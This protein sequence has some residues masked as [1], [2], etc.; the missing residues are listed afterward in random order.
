[1]WS[2]PWCIHAEVHLPDLNQTWT[3]SFVYLS[4][5]AEVRKVQFHSLR[6]LA[7]FNHLGDW[8][9]YLTPS[10]KWGGRPITNAQLTPFSEFISSSCLPELNFPQAFVST[11]Q[12]S[13]SDHR[14]LILHT[15]SLR[16]RVQ[17]PFRFVA[18]WTL[19][20]S[21]QDTI[22]SSWNSTQARGSAPFKLHL[23]MKALKLS[24]KHWNSSVVGNVSTRI[25][26]IKGQ[27]VGLNQ[28]SFDRRDD[29]WFLHEKELLYISI[30]RSSY[31]SRSRGSFG[32]NAV[33][34]TPSTSIC[35]QSDGGLATIL[36]S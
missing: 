22:S 31:G 2:T 9:S 15:H 14:A 32:L 4:C 24:L 28:I 11:E 18:L 1:M 33:T 7:E 20:Q 34:A 21:Y 8:N 16:W 10:D 5:V 12:L 29:R 17:R 19:E 23:K 3:M 27:L 13:S 35:P 25:E 6:N 30:K 36:A 26:Q